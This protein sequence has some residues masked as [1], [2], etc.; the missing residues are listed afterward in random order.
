MVYILKS[1]PHTTIIRKSTTLYA[2][3]VLWICELGKVSKSK[4]CIYI[5]TWFV[6]G[7]KV[8]S[9]CQQSD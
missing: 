6:L 8:F 5:R 2:H 3:P 9:A 7:F 4:I 1:F